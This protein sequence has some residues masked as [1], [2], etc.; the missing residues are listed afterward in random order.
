M[1]LH[2]QM[3]RN[4]V[5]PAA[6]P[7]PASPPCYIQFLCSA[8]MSGLVYANDRRNTF[9]VEPAIRAHAS[10][11]IIGHHPGGEHDWSPDVWQHSAPYGNF[12]MV[13]P[14]SPHAR[15]R[16]ANRANSIIAERNHHPMNT[17]PA[18]APLVATSAED[19]ANT[20]DEWKCGPVKICCSGIEKCKRA[21]L[22][23][24]RIFMRPL[25]GIR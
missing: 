21:C 24:V 16:K 17:N 25:I 2:A 5:L 11:D 14:W 8:T 23:M 10:M 13:W 1:A 22:F 7:P 6:K 4:E 9:H 12:L 3:L 18:R 19:A 15:D 20:D